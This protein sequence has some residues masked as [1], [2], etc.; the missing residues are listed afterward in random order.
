MDPSSILPQIEALAPPAWVPWIKFAAFV[1]TILG[2]YGIR[3][4]ERFNPWSR[5]WW[6]GIGRAVVGIFPAALRLVVRL[7]SI[8]PAPAASPA[9]SLV[10]MLNT[11][12][13][14][15]ALKQFATEAL[16]E[17]RARTVAI[18]AAALAAA[19]VPALTAAAIP[20]PQ[21]R[22]G[23]PTAAGFGF[24]AVPTGA[25]APT[26]LAPSPNVLAETGAL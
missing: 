4:P 7:V 5:A 9:L 2:V 21:V 18:A 8:R 13:A 14:Q 22:A 23:D 17:E 20:V 6:V 1:I 10:D 26:P 16:A 3:P 11:P 15:A 24:A 12:E 19:P 25:A